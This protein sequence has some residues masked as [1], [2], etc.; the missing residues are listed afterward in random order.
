MSKKLIAYFSASGT[1]KKVAEM[2][3]LSGGMWL[4][5]SSIHFLRNTTSQVKRLHC[6]QHRAEVDL[7]TRSMNSSR[8]H[9]ELSL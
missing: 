8:Q 3:S 1:T 6:L 2:D 5:R 9:R 7:A 4:Q